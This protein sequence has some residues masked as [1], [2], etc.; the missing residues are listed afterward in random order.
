[1]RFPF[2]SRD[3]YDELL[4]RTQKL[5]QENR[6]LLETLIPS[7]RATPMLPSLT[8]ET[9]LSGIQ[10]IANKPTLA[11]I[12]A[13]AN[14]AAAQRAKTPGS[15]SVVEELNEAAW[16]GRKAAKHGN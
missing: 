15:A 13:S 7:L 4:A 2:V 6:E 1:M 8:A 12:T 5:E 9:D 14:R 3:R 16:A 10:P 11:Q